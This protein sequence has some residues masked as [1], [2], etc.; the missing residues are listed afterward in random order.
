ML[1]WETK[2]VNSVLYIVVILT[3]LRHFKPIRTI[4]KAHKGPISNFA[5]GGTRLL[6]S[7]HDTSVKLWDLEKGNYI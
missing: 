1:L 4:N 6:S 7:S 3:Y 5:W 2:Y